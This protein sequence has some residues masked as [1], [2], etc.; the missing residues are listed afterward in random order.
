MIIFL[1]KSTC[2]CTCF[3]MC[4]FRSN[5]DCLPSG[6]GHRWW[7]RMEASSWR[8]VS[9][10]C[11]PYLV[12]QSGWVWSSVGRCGYWMYLQWAHGTSLHT[13]SLCSVHVYSTFACQ[14][15]IQFVMEDGLAMSY[16]SCQEYNVLLIM[17]TM[18]P[19]P[20]FVGLDGWIKNCCVYEYICNIM[21]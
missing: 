15:F 2:T 8:C 5:I 18:P 17:Y 6:E 11:L 10:S 7:V 13:V 4:Q 12:Y 9:S 20:L 16:A 3:C 21:S 14:D 19:C 1:C